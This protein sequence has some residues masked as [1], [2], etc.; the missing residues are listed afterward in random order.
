VCLLFTYNALWCKDRHAHKYT[1]KHGWFVVVEPIPFSDFSEI[2]V[3][4]T[5]STVI[6]EISKK[7]IGLKLVY[8]TYQT[9]T[10]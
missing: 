9:E 7:N 1:L 6:L 4:I 10:R 8:I 5:L 2:R 3:L